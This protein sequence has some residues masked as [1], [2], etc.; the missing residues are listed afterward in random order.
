MENRDKSKFDKYIGLYLAR[1]QEE[2]YG[3]F[4]KESGLDIFWPFKFVWFILVS[5]LRIFF[6]KKSNFDEFKK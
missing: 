1:F 4:K 3:A 5:F 6:R 2:K